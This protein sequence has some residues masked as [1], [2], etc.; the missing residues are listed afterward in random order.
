[1]LFEPSLVITGC[2][3]LEE[4]TF[5]MRHPR[6][7]ASTTNLTPC[8]VGSFVGND[9]SEMCLECEA[10]TF[11]HDRDSNTHCEMCASGRFS[12]SGATQCILCMADS[13]A[14]VCQKPILLG[15]ATEST[16]GQPHHVS[17]A[18]YSEGYLCQ[19][20]T[21]ASPTG[22]GIVCEECDA[23]LY[24]AD[25]DPQT[26]CN[27]CALGKYSAPGSTSCSILSSE[28]NIDNFDFSEEDSIS[29]FMMM[30]TAAPSNIETCIPCSQDVEEINFDEVHEIDQGEK[31]MTV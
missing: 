28:N 10:G 1:M 31:E 30:S 12:L 6:N 20:G 5:E 22:L 9:E 8:G 25:R 11:D 21:F 27:M 26:V 19:P 16:V 15:E 7:E 13:P 18:E 14:D 24:D 17:A 2:M 23:G 4:Y 29:N 3:P